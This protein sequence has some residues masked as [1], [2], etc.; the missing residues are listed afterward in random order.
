MTLYETDPEYTP[1]PDDCV[2]AGISLDPPGCFVPFSPELQ[3]KKS[4]LETQEWH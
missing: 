4:P 2:E 1:P 3:A